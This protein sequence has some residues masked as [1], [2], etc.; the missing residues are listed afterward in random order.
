MGLNSC[1]ISNESLK[2]NERIRKQ[3]IEKSECSL[4]RISHLQALIRPHLQK[5]KPLLNM[6]KLPHCMFKLDI[7]D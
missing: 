2:C 4:V 5:T 6:S 7:N 1:S 3:F